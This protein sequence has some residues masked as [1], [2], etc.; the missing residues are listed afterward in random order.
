MKNRKAAYNDAL[1]ALIKYYNLSKSQNGRRLAEK[2]MFEL[3]NAEIN[4]K[5]YELPMPEE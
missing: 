1:L 2:A 3:R 5:R 4:Q